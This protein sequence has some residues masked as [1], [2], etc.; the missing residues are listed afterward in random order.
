MPCF[1]PDLFILEDASLLQNSFEPPQPSLLPPSPTGEFLASISSEMLPYVSSVQR[2]EHN[3]L[4][5][6]PTFP[7]ATTAFL[8]ANVVGNHDPRYEGTVRAD[9]RITGGEHSYIAVPTIPLVRFTSCLSSKSY[10]ETTQPTPPLL[11]AAT[12]PPN[13]IKIPQ[14]SY[15]HGR[16]QWNFKPLEPI[17]FST[18]GR[19]GINLRDALHKEFAGLDGR[20]D[21]MLQGVGG[22]I[23]CRLL[24]CSDGFP[25]ER[26][27]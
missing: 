24:V 11:S 2:T 4:P 27:S 16:K 21:P 7:R 13:R 12:F 5:S 8:P 22:A 17:R 1:D 20:D 23:S 26:Q 10:L 3:S 19:P 15:D 25:P 6:L 14:K 18:N 9:S